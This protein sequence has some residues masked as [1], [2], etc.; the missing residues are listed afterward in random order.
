MTTTPITLD[1][2]RAEATKIVTEFG[3]GYRNPGLDDTCM[4]TDYNGDHCIA[5]Q[6]ATNLGAPCPD[7]DSTYNMDEVKV[8][9]MWLDGTVFTD[10]AIDY[11]AEVQ[12][13]A[14]S[15]ETWAD[16]VQKVANGTVLRGSRDI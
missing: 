1:Q 3:S 9:A 5:G 14:D 15:G 8:V 7:I 10:D 2:V 12:K 13:W 16:S 11:L 6:I 4:Y